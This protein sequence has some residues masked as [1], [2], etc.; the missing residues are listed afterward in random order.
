MNPP[1]SGVAV[2]LWETVVREFLHFQFVKMTM[3]FRKSRQSERKLV[4]DGEF[5]VNVAFDLVGFSVIKLLHYFIFKV[6]LKYS[7][8]IIVCDYIFL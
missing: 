2:A 5:S 6:V 7:Y 8:I 1:S 4:F 3:A